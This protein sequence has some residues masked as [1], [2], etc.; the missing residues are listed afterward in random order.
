MLYKTLRHAVQS[1]ENWTVTQSFYWSLC[2]V[3]RE[4][5]GKALR[6]YT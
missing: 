3:V 2:I 1:V 6:K 5:V 4:V